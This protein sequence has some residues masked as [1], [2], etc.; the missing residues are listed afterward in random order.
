[1]EA[2]GTRNIRLLV[3][4]DGTEFCG[5][6]IQKNERTVQ[7]ELQKALGTVLNAEVDLIG[8]GRTDT[9]VHAVGQ[10]ANFRTESVLSL[11]AIR[12]GGNSLLPADIVIREAEEAG[13]DFHARFQATSRRYAYRMTRARKAIG[14]QYAW[15]ISA[16]LDLQA[17]KEAD[18]GVQGRHDFTSFCSAEAH[19]SNPVCT[20]LHT[21]WTECED[22]LLW[23]IEADHFLQHMVRTLVGTLVEI[24]KGRWPVSF[25]DRVFK[26][27]DRRQ[28]GPTAPA[29]GLCLMEV[30]YDSREETRPAGNKIQTRR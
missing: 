25:L 1:M 28:A 17:M 20:V 10:V 27:K 5:W 8:A 21:N 12:R 30:T 7:G 13:P 23:E 3:E 24:G 26:A 9:G 2:Q 4:Y 16:G 14:R 22:G 11:L 18:A 29:H 19:H 15:H 6:Q